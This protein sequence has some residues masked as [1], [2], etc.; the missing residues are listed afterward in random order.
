MIFDH[1]WAKGAHASPILITQNVSNNVLSRFLSLWHFMNTF[2]VENFSKITR[3]VIYIALMNI[4][5]IQLKVF[6]LARISLLKT[7]AHVSMK[8]ANAS[9]NWA[10]MNTYGRIVKKTSKHSSISANVLSIYYRASANPFGQI[11]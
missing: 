8:K 9:S 10:S 11:V 2:A 6:T 1:D 4:F 5:T 3:L 7:F